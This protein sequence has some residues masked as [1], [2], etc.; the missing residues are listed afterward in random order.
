MLELADLVV[1]TGTRRVRRAGREIE[2]TK[3]EFD[4]LAL[5]VGNTPN[6]LTREVLHDRVWGHDGSYMSNS[7][8]V[9]VS[10]LRRKLGG[11]DLGPLIHTVRG[12]G[13]VARAG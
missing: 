11:D 5:L 2:L 9:A 12:V 3:L 8:E 13:Y 7:L 6:V 4:L 1:E 10:N